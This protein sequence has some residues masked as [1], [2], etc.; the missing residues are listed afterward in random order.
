MVNPVA[1][2]FATVAPRKPTFLQQERWK[3][4]KSQLQ[5]HVAAGNSAGVRDP[6]VHREKIS[7]AG[8]PPHCRHGRF[9]FRR[10][11]VLWQRNQTTFSLTFDTQP[12]RLCSAFDKHGW[13]LVGSIGM[14]IWDHPLSG[15]VAVD[16]GVHLA[17]DQDRAGR[18]RTMAIIMA[19]E[20]A[21]SV[22]SSR[23]AHSAPILARRKHLRQVPAGEWR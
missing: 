15:G 16:P 22:P 14:Q 23:S 13:Y 20:P 6:Q 3:V 10:Y 21:G 1:T 8:G 19:L 9:S 12:K 7:G 4:A 2:P 17:M 18:P 5:G 11:Q